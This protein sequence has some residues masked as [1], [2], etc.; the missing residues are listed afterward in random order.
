[1]KYEQLVAPT[2]AVIDLDV[3][4][5]HM[6]IEHS[7]DDELVTMM[8]RNAEAWCSGYTGKFYSEQTWALYAD[9][10]CGAISLPFYPI[11]SALVQYVDVD[12]LTQTLPDDQYY[13]DTKS[14]PGQLLPKDGITWPSLGDGPNTVT[15]TCVVGDNKVNGNVSAAILLLA[16]HLYEQRSETSPLNIRAV[17]HGVTVF[18]G[19][20]RVY[21]T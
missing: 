13:L 1:M 12:G 5:K 15:V 4:K 17:P 11:I 3:A 8:L 19:L 2:L 20:D 10:W 7:A 14:Y 6:Y 18:L 16:T 21:K 9:D